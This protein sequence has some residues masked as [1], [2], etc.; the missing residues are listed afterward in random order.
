VTAGLAEMHRY[1]IAHGDLKVENVL[2]YE[3]NGQPVAK[4]VSL[5]ILLTTSVSYQL[6]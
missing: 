3:D 1:G 2:V 4:L 5:R 6:I